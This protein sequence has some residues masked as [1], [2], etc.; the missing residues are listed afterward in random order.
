M[1]QTYSQLQA[2]IAKL[3]ST[4][5][6][7][8]KSELAEVIAKI[9]VAVTAYG[10]TPEDLFGG[11]SKG[12]TAKKSAAAP[13]SAS[14]SKSMGDLTARFADD[15]GNTWVGRGPR[16]AWLR[17]ALAKGKS[18][19]DYAIA[20]A[21]ASPSK[22]A[23][24]APPNAVKKVAVKA[25]VAAPK[26]PVA[27]KYSDGAGNSWT[28]RGSQPRWLKEAIAAGKTVDQFAV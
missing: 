28:G 10:I 12:S 27:A 23:K 18:L 20:G 15:T 9:R 3:Q 7:V 26:K 21:K 19:S 25:E 6:T 2:Q 4:A 14:S 22:D 5:E 13:K 8:R 24:T 1:A 11:K 16:P 17:E